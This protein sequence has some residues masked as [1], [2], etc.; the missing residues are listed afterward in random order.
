A[1]RPTLVPCAFEDRLS[2]DEACAR[3]F[4]GRTG[5]LLFRRPLTDAELNGRIA[6]T[7]AAA[8][9]VGDFHEG[10]TF[11]LASL[12]VAPEFLFI[13]EATLQNSGDG[14]RLA[15]FAK[16]SRLSFFLWNTAPDDALLVAAEQGELD[17]AAGLA[18][19][20]DRML[21]SPRLK[22]GVRAF[23]NDMLG[24]SG[25]DTLEK[26]GIIYP[27]FGQATAQDAREQTLRTI[28]DH[29]VSRNADYRDLFTTRRMFM[30]RPLGRVYRVQVGVAEGGWQEHEFPPESLRVGI[31]SHL[32]FLALYSH[33]GR[34]SP[35]QRGEA[36]RTALLC[37]KVPDPPGD[38][39]FSLFSDPN[40]P[41]KTARDRLS[42]H[43]TSPA[44]A[45]CHRITDPIGLALENYDGA[46][47]FRTAENGVTIDASGDL[48]GVPFTD[49]A[50][51]GRAIRDNPATPACLVS[52]MAAYATGRPAA[53][54][55]AWIT[56]LEGVF[57][58]GGYRVPELMRQIATSRGFFA[59]RLEK[60][61]AS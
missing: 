39:D 41:N 50:G 51:L 36:V 44:C 31:Q 20:V 43:A 12:L 23:F 9:E 40:S 54:G 33:P 6:L 21:A 26:D 1:H 56:Y 29:V 28:A 4:L 30:S 5:R 18:R 25:F 53:K 42:A 7:R 8:A 19:Q 57:S 16:A 15:P 27:A 46:G 52:R 14:A 58:E 59:V 48:D 3:D 10:L 17:D 24:F 11:G 45:G 35:T 55:D 61:E 32:S 38:V 13:T 47:Q 49:A 34:S 60:A 37:Q 2:F 22:S